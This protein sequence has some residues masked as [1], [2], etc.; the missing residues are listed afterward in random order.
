MLL[1]L[2]LVLL[3][4][5]YISSSLLHSTGGLSLENL[6][7]EGLLDEQIEAAINVESR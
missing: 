6:H 7:N 5:L 4:V 3:E 2:R 1:F